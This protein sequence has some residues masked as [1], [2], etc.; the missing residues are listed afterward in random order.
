MYLSERKLKLFV[1]FG[2]SSI[3]S[4]DQTK[5]YDWMREH[6]IQANR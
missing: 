6:S 3:K 2:E 1:S 4:R 5:P